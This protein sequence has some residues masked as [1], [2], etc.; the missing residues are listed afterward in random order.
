[1]SETRAPT[2]RD[3]HLNHHAVAPT[4]PA[5]MTRRDYDALILDDPDLAPPPRRELPLT[6][7]A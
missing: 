1:M 3:L 2:L 6:A 7:W 5:R 4:R